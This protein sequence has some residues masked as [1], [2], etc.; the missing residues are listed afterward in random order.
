MAAVIILLVEVRWVIVSVVIGW[1][2]RMPYALCST[3]TPWRTM[4]TS[5]AVSLSAAQVLRSSSSRS[6]VSGFMPAS[7]RVPARMTLA[8]LP[9]IGSGERNGSGNRC[10]KPY[11]RRLRPIHHCRSRSTA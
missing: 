10:S 3:M 11:S 1:P 4:H 8:A 9:S 2:L 6:A 7:T 5:K